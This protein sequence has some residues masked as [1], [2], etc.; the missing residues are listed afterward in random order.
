[1]GGAIQTTQSELEQFFAYALPGFLNY[2][3]QHSARVST[4]EKVDSLDGIYS[5]TA[6]YLDGGIEKQVLAPIKL[7]SANAEEQ[8]QKAKEAAEAANK[9]T[10]EAQAATVECQNATAE[11]QASKKL[12]DDATAKAKAAADAADGARLNILSV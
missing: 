2:V 6:L 7:L 12:C 5:L 1:M 3:S 11:A 10:E 8:A 9:A 4:I